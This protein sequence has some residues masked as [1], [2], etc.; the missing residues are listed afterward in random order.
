MPTAD[1]RDIVRKHTLDISPSC[2]SLHPLGGDRFVT[3]SVD[4]EWVRVY[5]ANSE[6][7]DLHK[8]HHG[9]VHCVSY[10]PDGQ[11]AA[12][13]SEDGTIRL[14]QNTP[15]AKYGLWA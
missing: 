9:P 7:L 12:S 15:G 10:T 3:G 11:V 13:G 4:D 5:D 14:W 2:A 8:G 6:Q 1:S